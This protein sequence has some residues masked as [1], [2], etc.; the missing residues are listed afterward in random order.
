MT[1]HEYMLQK[2]ID[3]LK[4]QGY[5]IIRLDHRIIPDA[6]AIKQK[7][8]IAVESETSMSGIWLT[9]RKFEN[10]QYD[11]EI[12]ITRPL[13]QCFHTPETY[14]E[15]LKLSKTGKS[16]REIQKLL[17]EKY[18]LKSLAISTIHSWIKGIKMP[19]L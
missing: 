19:R 15:V 5:R 7:E 4:K 1:E 10:S 3:E 9:R 12:V 14:K 6:I 8:V 18:K 16:Y 13:K 11:A 2:A 17:K